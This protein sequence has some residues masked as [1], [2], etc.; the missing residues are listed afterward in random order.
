MS[1]EIR[2]RAVAAMHVRGCVTIWMNVGHIIRRKMSVRI[3]RRYRL[4]I[5][6]RG[7]KGRYKG[8]ILTG[9]PATRQNNNEWKTKLKLRNISTTIRF[10]IQSR[11]LRRH[12]HTRRMILLSSRLHVDHD[13]NSIRINLVNRVRTFKSNF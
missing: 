1:V 8:E 5:K 3:R 10:Y 13:Q 7:R 4:A 6:M 11:G 2:H 12:V 9:G